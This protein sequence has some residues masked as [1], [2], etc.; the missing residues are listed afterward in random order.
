MAVFYHAVA[1]YG[2]PLWVTFTYA[3]LHATERI[4]RRKHAH[5]FWGLDAFVHGPD[6]YFRI[7]NRVFYEDP[8][9]AVEPSAQVIVAADG[10][11]A[12]LARRVLAHS[13]P[14]LICTADGRWS[15]PAEVVPSRDRI[16]DPAGHPQIGRPQA[17][18][19]C[20]IDSA[21]RVVGGGK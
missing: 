18:R 2:E 12:E 17:V 13:T 4:L 19:R 20:V 9:Q 11:A 6:R 1:R 5:R 21:H 3:G 14:T 16:S 8:E 15:D 7:A 10:W